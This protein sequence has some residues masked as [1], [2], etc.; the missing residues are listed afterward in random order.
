M[1]FDH[2]FIDALARGSLLS[3]LGL[4]WIILLVR[5]VGLRSFSKMTNFDFVMT[6]AMGSLLAGAAQANSWLNLV[7]IITAMSA[8]FAIQFAVSRLRQRS[9]AFDDAIQNTPVLLM[10]DGIVLHEALRTTRVTEGDLMAKL[11]EANAIE[12]STVRAVVLETTG[13]VSVLHGEQVDD[14][15]LKAIRQIH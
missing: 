7:Q 12:L 9:D 3:A 4:I 6:V 10:K 1:F 11:R 2:A 5:L 13:D 8:L 15:L 14:A